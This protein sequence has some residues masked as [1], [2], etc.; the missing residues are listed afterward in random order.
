M[1]VQNREAF[2]L[3][4][5]GFGVSEMEQIME[6]GDEEDESLLASQAFG[7]LV[8][9]SSGS[10]RDLPSESDGPDRH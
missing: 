1:R 8:I 2:G 3:F 5:L 4:R 6:Y 9:L 10:A 7:D